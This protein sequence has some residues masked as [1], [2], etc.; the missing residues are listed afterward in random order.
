[1]EWSY[2][3]SL[4]VKSMKTKMSFLKRI[5]TYAYCWFKSSYG[6]G[7]LEIEGEDSKESAS[8]GPS[9]GEGQVTVWAPMDH[10]LGEE[11]DSTCIESW[12]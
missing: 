1:M 3:K 10:S 8:G 2:L 7:W 11:E 4:R 9:K 12:H 5:P 6:L